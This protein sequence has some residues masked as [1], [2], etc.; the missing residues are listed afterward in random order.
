VL[1]ALPWRGPG[2]DRPPLPLPPERMPLLRGG[3]PLKAWRWAGAFGPDV[4]V[5]AAAVRVAGVPL[6]WWA[7]WDAPAGRLRRRFARGSGGVTVE[8]GR[9][10]IAGR[11][12][13]ALGDA[14]PIEVVSRHGDQYIWTRKRAGMD[15]GGHVLGRPVRLRAVLDESAGY[16]ARETAWT[17]SAGVG[18]LRGGEAVAWNLVDGVHDAPAASEQTVWVDGAPRE[19]AAPDFATLGFREQAAVERRESLLVASSDY[20]QAF[21]AFAGELSG[22]G[23]L[24][25]GWGVMERHAVRW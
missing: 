8:A 2:P 16:H 12:E 3:R 11:A 4:M 24:R 19:V 25:E 1:D 9:L 6:A 10:A 20:F 18:V 17:W 5:V 7:I 14:A 22:A 23:A 13:L 21:G 15:A